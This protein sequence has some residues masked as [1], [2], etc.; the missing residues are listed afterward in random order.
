MKKYIVSTLF[1]ILMSAIFLLSHSLYAKDEPGI[2]NG[3][4]GIANYDLS[5]LPKKEPHSLL[6]VRRD[7]AY[8]WDSNQGKILQKVI[9]EIPDADGKI[10]VYSVFINPDGDGHIIIKHQKIDRKDSGAGCDQTFDNYREYR[11]NNTGSYTPYSGVTKP[12]PYPE[13]YKCP[14]NIFKPQ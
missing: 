7:G 6:I 11:L 12:Y 3:V 2:I 10:Q 9:K 14:R 1:L 13:P 8:Y 5:R 4:G